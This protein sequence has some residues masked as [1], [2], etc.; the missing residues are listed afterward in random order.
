LHFAYW[1]W[2]WNIWLEELQCVPRLIVALVQ[3]LMRVLAPMQRLERCS[4]FALV[5]EAWNIWPEWQQYGPH[6]PWLLTW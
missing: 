4:L 2:V 3:A 5:L 6:L 1:V